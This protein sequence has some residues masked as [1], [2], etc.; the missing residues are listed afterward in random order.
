[1]VV[2]RF[3]WTRAPRFGIFRVNWDIVRHDSYVVITACEA[4]LD[5]SV[6]GR[7][8]GGAR[9]VFVGSISPQYQYVE[10]SMWWGLIDASYLNIWTDVVV[11]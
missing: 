6:P 5:V 11:I 10:F 9:P 2:Q 1:M 8:I 7:F 3:L 4:K